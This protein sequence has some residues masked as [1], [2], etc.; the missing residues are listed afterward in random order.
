M[1]LFTKSIRWPFLVVL[2]YGGGLF[3]QSKPT[4]PVFEVSTTKFLL[5]TQVDIIA[6]G[7]KRAGSQKGLLFCFS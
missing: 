4:A 2:L 7:K 3:A 5:G 1:A 6:L